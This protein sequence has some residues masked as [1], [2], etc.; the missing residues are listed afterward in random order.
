MPGGSLADMPDDAVPRTPTTARTVSLVRIDPVAEAD[1]LVQFMTSST[2]PFHGTSAPTPADVRQAVA[3]GRYRSAELDAFWVVDRY[4]ARVGF[5][6]LE[7]VQD[8]T[9]M[10]DLRIAQQHRGRGLGSAALRAA[11][12][13]V[14]ETL[15][16]AIRFEGTT[17]VDN[18]AMRRTFLA[19][20]WAKEAH[21]RRAWP[22]GDGQ[23]L[24]AVAYA[25]LREDWA[26]GTRTPVTWD[27]PPE[28]P[29]H[30]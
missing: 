2:F 12:R 24:D 30:R 23:H 17:R 16:E 7:D 1:D 27:D 3:E 8:A 6:R 22:T 15:P 18:L 21:Y 26:D 29:T 28:V 19:C 11:T 5:L 13:Q 9:P 14:F 4:A 25:V 10:L 20:G